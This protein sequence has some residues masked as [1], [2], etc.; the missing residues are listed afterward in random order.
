MF[1]FFRKAK[2]SINSITF[3]DFGW[4]KENGDNE[5]VKWYNPER[6]MGLALHF[7]NMVPDA[8]KGDIDKIRA[9]YQKLALVT[10]SGLVEVTQ[11]VAGGITGI[12]TI[13][14]LPQEPS[15][16]TYVASLTMPFSNCSYVIK[17]TAI[18][19]G[20]TGMREALIGDKLLKNG[21]VALADG[22]LKGWVVEPPVS[23][24]FNMNQSELEVYDRDFPSHHLSI[25]RK[26][27]SDIEKGIV[28]LPEISTLKPFY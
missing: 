17:I 18:E 9:A 2:P 6:T 24:S 13:F 10:L 20:T 28:F 5:V 12:K 7:F 11:F 23:G 22:Q 8:P 21:S 26:L 3:P 1:S 15:G 19:P 27:I 25:I 16:I 14:K 4:K